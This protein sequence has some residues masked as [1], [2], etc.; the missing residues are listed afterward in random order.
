MRPKLR[1]APAIPAARSVLSL[2]SNQKKVG[3][4][5][6]PRGARRK[7]S[8][9]SRPWRPKSSVACAR[10]ERKATK[11]TTPSKRRNRSR[12]RTRLDGMA[13]V[14]SVGVS[15]EPEG[16]AR[17]RGVAG[18]ERAPGVGERS[19]A[20][21]PAGP[22]LEPPSRAHAEAAA[23]A[24]DDATWRSQ[25]PGFPGFVSHPAAR[26]ACVAAKAYA[27][28]G[29][30]SKV[31]G[32]AVRLARCGWRRRHDQRDGPNRR[33]G[34]DADAPGPCVARRAGELRGPRGD[35][36]RPERRH[37]REHNRGHLTLGHD[38]RQHGRRGRG[39][40]HRDVR[41]GPVGGSSLVRR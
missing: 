23:A 14:V 41:N 35:R 38:T 29:R 21:P 20:D 13:G 28:L 4:S 25:L 16:V 11:K 10:R 18:V 33:T 3:A 2:A 8:A 32:R 26:S 22:A 36:L 24:G 30:Y 1:T 15:R 6:K 9:G 17:D 40:R 27:T 7:S 31:N 19:E 34:P 39:Y 5:R 12:T 37:Q